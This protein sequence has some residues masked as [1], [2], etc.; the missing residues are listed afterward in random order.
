MR[1]RGWRVGDAALELCSFRSVW[2]FGGCLRA[3]FCLADDWA[4]IAVRQYYVVLAWQ[5]GLWKP[6]VVVVCSLF[7]LLFCANGSR[8]GRAYHSLTS[9]S[10]VFVHPTFRYVCIRV[11]GPTRL[12]IAEKASGD[13]GHVR[14]E[15]VPRR[16][17]GVWW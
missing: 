1:F 12:A 15:L 5:F 11:F 6:L 17:L 14:M 8:Y 9:E 10:F 4:A 3:G 13:H 7:V 2:I 16:C